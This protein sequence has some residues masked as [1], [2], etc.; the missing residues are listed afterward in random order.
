MTCNKDEGGF[1]L[2]VICYHQG[3]L[4]NEPETHCVYTFL[5]AYHLENTGPYSSNNEFAG[6]GTANC[7]KCG[8]G[9]FQGPYYRKKF[10]ILLFSQGNGK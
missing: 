7:D 2:C 1:D 10:S 9:V 8:E 6:E 5:R 4:C 3:Q